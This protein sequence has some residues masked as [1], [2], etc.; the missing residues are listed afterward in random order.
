MTTEKFQQEENRIT[1][2]ELVRLAPKLQPHLRLPEPTWPELI[3]AADL[4]RNDLGVSKSLWSEAR[5]AMGRQL[6]AVALAIVSTKDPNQFTTSPAVFFHGM[7]AKHVAGE[8]HLERTV[9]ALRRAI[10]P[11]HYAR[12][13]RKSD[14][15]IA[16]RDR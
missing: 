8:L 4:L 1:P 7:V 16:H 11:D 9:W 15:G 6:A 10:D 12:K 14:R 2:N 13:D 3:D 5:V